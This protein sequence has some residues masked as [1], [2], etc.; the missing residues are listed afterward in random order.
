M[1]TQVFGKP[2]PL[3]KFRQGV[4]FFIFRS[5]GTMEQFREQSVQQSLIHLLV[6]R[7]YIVRYA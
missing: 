5:P 1:L 6:A 4:L 7:N 2:P 3:V